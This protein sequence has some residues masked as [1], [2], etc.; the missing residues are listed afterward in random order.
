MDR[1]KRRWRQVHNH[2]GSFN[3]PL[4]ITGETSRPKN[5]MNM[6]DLNSTRFKLH[7]RLLSF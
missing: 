2:V 5:D 4:P 1:I 7:P 3:T 6:E